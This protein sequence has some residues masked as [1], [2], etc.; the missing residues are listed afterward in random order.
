MSPLRREIDALRRLPEAERLSAVRAAFETDAQRGV[1]LA[2]ALGKPRSI[3]AALQ[4]GVAH[5]DPSTMRFCVELAVARL[6]LRRVA[7]L[8]DVLSDTHPAGVDAA[9]YWARMYPADPA[10]RAV[11]DRVPP[12]VRPLRDDSIALEHVFQEVDREVEALRDDADAPP[13]RIEARRAQ[14]RLAWAPVERC[15]AGA[16]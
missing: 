4:L 1:A 10:T 7:A 6:G 13:A 9:L 14:L 12:A 11:L 15:L 5:A 2:A 3:E 8:L 16:V